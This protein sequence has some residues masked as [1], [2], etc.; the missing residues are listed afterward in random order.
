MYYIPLSDQIAKIYFI[1]QRDNPPYVYFSLQN[2]L[3]WVYNS[4]MLKI[5]LIPNNILLK[6]VEPVVKIDSKIKKLV[7]DMEEAL[8]SQIDPQGVG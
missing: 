7:Y 3:R 6:P 4:Y 5:V 8:I 2:K 1:F